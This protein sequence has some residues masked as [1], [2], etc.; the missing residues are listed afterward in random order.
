MWKR[1]RDRQRAELQQTSSYKCVLCYL[2]YFVP[3]SVAPSVRVSPSNIT[4]NESMDVLVRCEYDANPQQLIYVLWWVRVHDMMLYNN[5]KYFYLAKKNKGNTFWE[6]WIK[7]CLRCIVGDKHFFKRLSGKKRSL[8]ILF[9]FYLFPYIFIPP[10]AGKRLNRI[11]FSR[12]LIVW[13]FA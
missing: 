12:Y 3:P 13:E 11:L 9:L 10:S 2:I 6:N 1:F 7:L 8:L 5:N 4:V